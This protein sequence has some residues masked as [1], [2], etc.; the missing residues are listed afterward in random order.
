MFIRKEEFTLTN[1][2]HHPICSPVKVTWRPDDHVGTITHKG[3]SLSKVIRKRGQRV[4]IGLH[5]LKFPYKLCQTINDLLYSIASLPRTEKRKKM[6]LAIQIFKHFEKVPESFDL[7]KMEMFW[8][9]IIIM[10][11]RWED[12]HE[13][14]YKG[15]PYYL[16]ARTYLGF[17]DIPSAYMCFFTALEEDKK[18]C[19][20]IQENFRDRPAYLTTSLVDDDGNPLYRS[21]V[22]SLRSELQGFINSY[23]KR[24]S[25]DFTIQ[26]LDKKFLQ[27]DPLEDAKRFFVA[28][29]HEIS[30]L[31]WLNFSRMMKNDY[32]KLKTADTLFNIALI[33]DQVLEY[34]FLKNRGKMDK[35]MA[36][37][38]YHLALHLGWTTTKNSPDVSTFLKKIEPNLNRGSPDTIIPTLL[39][40]TATYDG[41]PLNARM[42]AIFA[43]YHLRNYGGHNIR[44]SD[45]LINRYGE[46]LDAVMDAFF[47]SIQA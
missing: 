4:E 46:I 43:A 28:N 32:S 36:N 6:N 19:S 34:R 7:K 33:I 39:D 23:N 35:N 31:R 12:S 9:G 2:R 37:A 5:Y 47:V 44:G 20:Y 10:V 45:I 1:T 14:I 16:L 42:R 18:N 40:G 27:A 24:T 41:D 22:L 17:G 38:I 3:E 26:D 13:E 30:H 11:W 29:F 25:S 8:R 15:I 21:V